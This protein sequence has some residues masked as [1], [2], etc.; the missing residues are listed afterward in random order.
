ML[1][2]VKKTSVEVEKF[3]YK[4]SFIKTLTLK[5]KFLN[6]YLNICNFW[7]ILTTEVYTED[8]ISFI[9]NHRS[10]SLK[11]SFYACG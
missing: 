11:R 5:F 10:D 1:I 9:A 4:I 3:K 7:K 8:L 6:I 2:I